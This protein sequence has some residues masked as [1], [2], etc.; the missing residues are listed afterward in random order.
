[1][2]VALCFWTPRRAHGQS[3]A[4]EG[5]RQERSSLGV[6]RPGR[7]Q[8]TAAVSGTRAL[9]AA[10]P[11]VSQGAVTSVSGTWP[12]ARV[13]ASTQRPQRGARG[14][15][16]CPPAL[17]ASLPALPGLLL[18]R[19]WLLAAGHLRSGPSL[20]PPLLPGSPSPAT[21][22]RLLLVCS[23]V[24]PHAPSP[25]HPLRSRAQAWWRVLLSTFP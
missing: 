4:R 25:P 9:S 6:S 24:G 17:A 15:H 5:C 14:E 12:S 3:S 18:L 10:F 16:P 2:G 7:G 8:H 19:L 11:T 22:P 20:G 21:V 13:P 23:G 1:M